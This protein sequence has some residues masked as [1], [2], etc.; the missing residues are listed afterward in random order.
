MTPIQILV[1]I[2][3]H[4][5]SD[6]LTRGLKHGLVHF[7]KSSSTKDLAK[8]I[9]LVGMAHPWNFIFLSFLFLEQVSQ[10]VDGGS[11]CCFRRRFC[12]NLNDLCRRPV[13]CFHIFIRHFKKQYSV[14][15]QNIYL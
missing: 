4:L 14:G 5:N 8:V 3:T 11:L 2:I 15:M 9:D 7:S 13:L 10:W 1:R 6:L 12:F